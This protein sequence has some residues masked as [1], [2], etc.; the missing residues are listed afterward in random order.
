MTHAGFERR[1][2][3]VVD[4]FVKV[5]K[6]YVKWMKDEAAK[7]G[8]EMEDATDQEREEAVREELEMLLDDLYVSALNCWDESE[9]DDGNPISWDWEVTLEDTGN[10]H[11]SIYLDGNGREA[12]EIARVLR[13]EIKKA[14]V[15]IAKGPA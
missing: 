15:R 2:D 3:E 6:E 7:V 9:D 13:A 4:A 11:A 8:V 5:A 10:I 12:E 14:G 1:R